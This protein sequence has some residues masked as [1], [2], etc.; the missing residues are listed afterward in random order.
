MIERRFIS[1]QEAEL[2]AYTEGEQKTIEGYAAKFNV[3]SRLLS[4]RG[5]IF[6]EVLLQGAFAEVLDNDVYLT[7]NHNQ[8][9][10]Y[11]RTVNGTLTLEQD[12]IGLRFK[13]MLN[14][15]TG[16]ND[17]YK[18]IERGDIFE[19]SFAFVVATGGQNWERTSDGEQI[20]RI[21]RISKL[22]DV[23]AVTHAAYPETELK[24][25]RGIDE[26]MPEDEKPKADKRYI[27]ES[28][29]DQIGYLFHRKN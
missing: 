12:E 27:D 18:M 28:L 21:S 5:Q 17:L 11:A 22:I 1:S 25:A 15:T 13:A 26:I 7:F 24:V 14:D 9:N 10:V 19:N 8:N 3:E 29:K 2:R 4:E 20:R 6:R 23:S 16:A